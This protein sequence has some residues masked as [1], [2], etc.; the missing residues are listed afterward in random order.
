MRTRER[1]SVIDEGLPMVRETFLEH[2]EK[3]T[4]KYV[5]ASPHRTEGAGWPYPCF[6]SM[7]SG[8]PFASSIEFL[9]LILYSM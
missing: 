9:I 7:L 6:Q 2:Q 3:G 5:Q 8:C 1:S 4:R